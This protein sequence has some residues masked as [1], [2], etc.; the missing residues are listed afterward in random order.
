MFWNER[1]S[2]LAR[3][4]LAI[5]LRNYGLPIEKCIQPQTVR[6]DVLLTALEALG[7]EDG[8]YR[9]LNPQVTA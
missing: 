2:P 9:L 3:A 5:S 1:P 8:R 4:W 7:C 6:P